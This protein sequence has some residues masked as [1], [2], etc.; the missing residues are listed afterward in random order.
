M[1]WTIVGLIVLIMMMVVVVTKIM[2]VACIRGAFTKKK[3]GKVG[4]LDQSADPPP[5]P[6]VG[7]P[8]SEIF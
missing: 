7:T 1:N 4:L 6:E 5:S 8:L 2:V 3:M